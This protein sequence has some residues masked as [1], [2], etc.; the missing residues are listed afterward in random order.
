[1]NFVDTLTEKKITLDGVDY[2]LLH[3]G[4]FFKLEILRK[5]LKDHLNKRDI[6]EFKNDIEEIVFL[7]TR[8]RFKPASFFER[9]QA[10]YFVTVSNHFIIDAPIFKPHK[11]TEIEKIPSWDYEG[12]TLA[13]WINAFAE[14]YHWSLFEILNLPLNMAVYL[15]QEIAVNTQL[16]REW[17]YSLTELAYPYNET[18][19]KSEFKPLHRPDWMQDSPDTLIPVTKIRRDMLPDGVVMD[20]SGMGTLSRNEQSFSLSKEQTKEADPTG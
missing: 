8:N 17:E 1:M 14:T 16:K 7:Q 18:L 13:I 4:D 19:K 10:A 12:R 6:V 15:Y 3:L 20:Y 11:A 9:L 2:D 5:K